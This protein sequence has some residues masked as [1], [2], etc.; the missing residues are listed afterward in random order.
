MVSATHRESASR[1]NGILPVSMPTMILASR[2][3]CGRCFSATLPSGT[4]HPRWLAQREPS[5]NEQLAEHLQS[6]L[7]G[8]C[9]PVANVH[10]CSHVAV[11]AHCVPA[12]AF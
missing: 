10:V 2:T 7:S 6:R 11:S 9:Q 12:L 4:G 8:F 5:A 1:L 3:G